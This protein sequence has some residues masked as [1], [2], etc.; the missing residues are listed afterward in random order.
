MSIF[1]TEHLILDFK[2]NKTKTKIALIQILR[3]DSSLL[4]WTP[5]A[6]LFLHANPFK[7]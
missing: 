2:E 7:K 1:E 5:D 3:S 6:A 4:F